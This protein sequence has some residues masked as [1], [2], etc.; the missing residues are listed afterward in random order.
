MTRFSSKAMGTT[1]LSMSAVS[2]DLRR[3]SRVPFAMS[4]VPYFLPAMPC[5]IGVCS[6]LLM[7]PAIA[8]EGGRKRS[9]SSSLVS[10]DFLRPRM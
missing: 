5:E 3:S 9:S 10:S 1:P 8:A 2:S 6:V 7:R 4:M